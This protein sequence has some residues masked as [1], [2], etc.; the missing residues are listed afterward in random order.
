[1]PNRKSVGELH[2]NDIV[3]YDGK[4]RMRVAGFPTVKMVILTAL[5]LQPGLPATVKTN[6][7]D[8]KIVKVEQHPSVRED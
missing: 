4:Q 3:I 2:T 5:V 8:K 1:M 6:V 7:T